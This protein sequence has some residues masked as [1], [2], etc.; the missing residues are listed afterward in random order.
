MDAMQEMREKL[1]VSAISDV[2]DEAKI[3]QEKKTALLIMRS[4]CQFTP[5]SETHP[6]LVLGVQIPRFMLGLLGWSFSSV[7]NLYYDQQGKQI[8]LQ[9]K[10]DDRLPEGFLRVLSA[11][12][13]R[14]Q[15]SSRLSIPVPVCKWLGLNAGDLVYVFCDEQTE[16]IYI[17]KGF[18]AEIK[19]PVLPA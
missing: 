2:I 7:V 14:S 10:E 13:H 17:Y 3:K 8:I 4:V 6:N 15:S 1:T 12:K 16:R 18:R 11:G 9:R 5:R 19:E